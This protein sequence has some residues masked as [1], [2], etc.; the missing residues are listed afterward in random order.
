MYKKV[1]FNAYDTKAG[2]NHA[3]VVVYRLAVLPRVQ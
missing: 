1:K 3:S 2:E